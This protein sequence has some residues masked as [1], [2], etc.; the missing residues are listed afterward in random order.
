MAVYREIRRTSTLNHKV[1][2][3]CIVLV[4]DLSVDPTQ[5]PACGNCVSEKNEEL[6]RFAEE[7]LGPQY[8]RAMRQNIAAYE[9]SELPIRL[10]RRQKVIIRPLPRN[11]AGQYLIPSQIILVDNDAVCGIKGW[12]GAFVVGHELGHKALHVKE[13]SK[14]L[15]KEVSEILEVDF[16]S[17]FKRLC[18]VVADEVGNLAS[19][20]NEDRRLFSYPIERMKREGIQK[21][22][23]RFC[24]D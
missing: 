14:A 15:L 8:F 2:V 21:A 12:S 24:W 23:L 13:G 5:A 16:Q 3:E 7:L 10:I 20:S 6:E 11:L 9:R 22:I 4:P 18:E 19:R 17:N 1:E